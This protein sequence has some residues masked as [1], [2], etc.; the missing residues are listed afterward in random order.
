MM[1]RSRRH[2]FNGKTSAANDIGDPQ[3][4]DDVCT[5]SCATDVAG[6]YSEKQVEPLSYQSSTQGEI[7]K[8]NELQSIQLCPKN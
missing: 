1:K 8:Q 6:H 3:P 4:C 5:S 2:T 7:T